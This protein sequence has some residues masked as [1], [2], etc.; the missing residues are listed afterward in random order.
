[1]KLLTKAEVLDTTLSSSVLDDLPAQKVLGVRIFEMLRG[2]MYVEYALLLKLR[3][4]HSVIL[5]RGDPT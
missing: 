1:M 4:I 5:Q 2:I 3:Q